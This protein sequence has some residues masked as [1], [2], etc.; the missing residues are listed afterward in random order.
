MKDWTGAS[1]DKN[2]MKILVSPV[3]T[4]N[5]KMATG[6]AWYCWWKK[7][8]TR[9]KVKLW[10][11][12]YIYVVSGSSSLRTASNSCH[13]HLSNSGVWHSS[14]LVVLQWR[15]SLRSKRARF[16]AVTRVEYVVTMHS[17]PVDALKLHDRMNHLITYGN[18]FR[19]SSFFSLWWEMT[20]HGF[21]MNISGWS[22][23]FGFTH[24][25][26]HTIFSSSHVSSDFNCQ[27]SSN[28]RSKCCRN[29][30]LK[31]TPNYPPNKLSIFHYE[32]FPFGRHGSALL[33]FSSVE[34]KPVKASPQLYHL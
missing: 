16:V 10:C 33:A 3:P 22:A 27:T 29:D 17:S 20:S 26:M 14:F 19:E 15:S 30:Y 8:G 24:P 28:W 12:L 11:S 5:L 9:G 13:W 18:G 6:L 4:W 23:P 2:G 25:G 34:T 21:W 1:P 32:V 7:S 31:T